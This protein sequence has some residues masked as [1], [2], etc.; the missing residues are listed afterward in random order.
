MSEGQ[1]LTRGMREAVGV[2]GFLTETPPVG[3]RIKATVD[4]FIVEEVPMELPASEGGR[5]LLA[6]VTARNWETNRLVRELSR[7]LGTSRTRISFAGTKDKR[8]ITTQ[9]MSFA[10]VDA[11]ELS[12]VHLKDVVLEP[13]HRSARRLGLGHLM[14]NRFRVRLR[15]ISLPTE[16]VSSRLRGLARELNSTGGFP[17]FFGPQRFGESRPISHLVGRALVR[18]D[19]R[20]AVE[21]YLGHPEPGERE[22]AYRARHAFE[23]SGDVARAL[24]DYPK[25]LSFERALLNH[26]RRNSGDYAGA[27]RRLPLN[28]LTLF[29]YAYQAFLFNRILSLRLKRGLGLNEPLV[30]DLVLPM[31]KRGLPRRDASVEVTEANLNKV[32]ERVRAGKAWISGLVLGYDVPFATGAMGRLEEEVVAE[33]GVRPEDFTVSAMPRLSSRG[34]RRGILA[35][36]LD[37][38][39]EVDGDVILSF[40]LN[41]GCYATALLR[42]FTKGGSSY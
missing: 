39:Y 36:L 17:N 8:A 2:S 29:V 27:L 15:D 30:G 33:E 26:L 34:L 21:T 1:M 3:G 9:L 4:D 18:G 13:L 11:E 23:E 41:P 31:D 7:R 24:R 28:L 25:R 35:S 22:D 37:F 6:R 20:G 14:G 16:E 10:G 32:R 19:L 38:S 5:F 40:R 42:E 12:R